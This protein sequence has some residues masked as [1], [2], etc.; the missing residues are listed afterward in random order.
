LNHEGN[1]LTR[2]LRWLCIAV[3]LSVP[4]AASAEDTPAPPPEPIPQRIDRLAASLQTIETSLQKPDLSD[5][6]LADLRKQT[7]PLLGELQDVLTRLNPQLAG[8]KARLDQLGPKPDEKAPPESPQVTAERAEQQDIFNKTDELIKRTRLLAVQADQTI[9]HIATRRHFLFTKLLFQSTTGIGNPSLWLRVIE[10]LPR[11]NNNAKEVFLEWIGGITDR[12]DG[13]RMPAFSGL[14]ALIFVLYWPLSR[15]SRAVLSRKRSVTE[16]T[17]FQKILGAWWVAFGIAIVP[18][19][20]SFA[21]ALVFETFE[22]TND[23]LQPF[24]YALGIG[25]LRIA[26]AG[27]IARGLLAPTRPHWRLPQINDVTAERIVRLALGVA[28]AVSLTRLFESLNDIVG[29]SLPVSIALRGIGALI[30]AIFIGFSLRGIIVQTSNPADD[31]LG[32]PV[33][34]TSRWI[35]L[36][37]A[38]GWALVFAIV[39][40]VF[41]GYVALGSFI[42]DQIVWVSGI[43]SLF[44]MSYVLIDEFIANSMLPEARVSQALAVNI[45]IEHQ[46]LNLF[47]VLLSGLARTVLSILAILLILA[48]WGVQ[49]TDVPSGLRAAFFGLQVGDITLSL[50]GVATSLA[51]FTACYGATHV[52]TRWLDA[53]FLPQTNLD[54]GLRNSIKTSI[55]YLGFIGALLLALSNLGLNFERLAIVAGALSV[56][57]GFGLQA[58]VNNFLSGLILLWERAVR[59]GDWIVIGEEQGVVRRI[60]V[61]ATEIETFDR[62]LVIVPNANLVTGIVKNWVR[63]DRGGRLKIPISLNHPADPEKVKDIL[64]EA[65]QTHD[66]IIAEPAPQVYLTSITQTALNFDLFAFVEDV[67]TIGR[68]KSDL[69]FDIF[70]RFAAAGIDMAPASAGPV[71]NITG[72]EKLEALLTP[73]DSGFVRERAKG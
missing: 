8:L 34:M 59:V 36:M 51:L 27:G 2:V 16:P 42:V 13:W 66:L 32:P 68:V 46:S 23:K 50:S 14:V 17:R 73:Q 30:V 19:G 3:V 28:I 4:F 65:A 21:L 43:V 38:L 62:A 15:M 64:L 9:N 57:I 71:I 60:N 48:P 47:G 22:L 40:S 25:V 45:G 11:D 44:F 53:S 69:Y 58:I 67:E 12:V 7:E 55:S 39:A 1:P 72:L 26:L 56:G 61:R 5:S 37:R 33:A 6:V 29:A 24:M 41:T 63:T 49:T 35:Q 20:A 18:I 70:K 31:C 10:E 52:A 54:I